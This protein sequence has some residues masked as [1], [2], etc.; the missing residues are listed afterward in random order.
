M[1]R[2]TLLIAMV[3]IL[4]GCGG[5]ESGPVTTAPISP[6]APVVAAVV[7]S[8]GTSIEVG[9]TLQL[10]AVA[11]T[12]TGATVDGKTVSWAS[13]SDAI[14]AVSS[15]GLVTA[16][17]EG[18]A[19]L[20]AT[21]DGK[22]GSI[23]LLV[24]PAAGVPASITITGVATLEVNATTKLVAVVKDGLGNPVSSAVTWSSSDPTIVYVNEDGSAGALRIG[25]VTIRAA[26][27]GVSNTFVLSGQMK[28][29][30][31]AFDAGISVAEQQ[32]VRD[33]VLYAYP[34]YQLALT[35]PPLAPFPV[36]TP[37]TSATIRGVLSS[38]LCDAAIGT[39]AR[40][41][42]SVIT[43]C[44]ASAGW[45]ARGPVFRQKIVAHELFHRFQAQWNSSTT[46]LTSAEWALEGMA[47]LMAASSFTERN[48]MSLATWRACLAE[49]INA[50][51]KD[52]PPGLPGLSQME[53][54]N[55]IQNV[56]GPG[57]A[58][59]ALAVD[60]LSVGRTL[61]VFNQY[62]GISDEA[63]FPTTFGRTRSDFYS[64]APRYVASLPAPVAGSCS[65]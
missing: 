63:S 12:A 3:A 29:F 23:T 62:V 31:I 19:V 46:A 40:T 45:I 64:D 55:S 30:P 27:G 59:A 50:Y 54:L 37:T 33:A 26:I 14:A 34:F 6:A 38:P 44:M 22:S 10:L 53:G 17:G 32:L 52:H 9:K 2:L 61:A 4:A 16:R 56:A 35:L 48:L 24:T 43:V 21:V 25:P 39:V 57:Y 41:V 47:E 5:G 15:S 8:G 28:S 65:I 20:T 49:E 1:M 11:R 7:V 58:R 60:Q 42:G 13:S 51:A 36:F 18:S